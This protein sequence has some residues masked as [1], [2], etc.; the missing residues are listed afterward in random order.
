MTHFKECP[1]LIPKK[2]A[3]GDS[4]VVMSDVGGASSQSIRPKKRVAKTSMVVIDIGKIVGSGKTGGGSSKHSLGR[5]TGQSDGPAKRPKVALSPD[6][7]M[8]GSVS[9]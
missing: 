6:I 5:A 2:K 1:Q 8:S 3:V 4:D 7:V 9:C